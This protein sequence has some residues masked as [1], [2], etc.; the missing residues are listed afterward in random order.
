MFDEAAPKLTFEE[1][2]VPLN[3]QPLDGEGKRAVGPP[4]QITDWARG[5]LEGGGL[6]SPASSRQVMFIQGEAGRGKSVFC[7]MFASWARAHF[8]LAWVPILIR[9]RDVQEIKDNLSGTLTSQLENEDFVQSDAG[10]L[11]DP[12]VRFLL[13]F[14]G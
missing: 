8:R 2:Y 5:V 4:R 12:N 14:D 11:T 13:I 9:L 3:V 1:L 7:R 6:A 10:W